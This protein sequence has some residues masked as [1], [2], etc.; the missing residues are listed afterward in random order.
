MYLMAAICFVT[1]ASQLLYA[2]V[3]IGDISL[4]LKVERHKH[5]VVAADM[6]WPSI[7]YRR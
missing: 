3:Y 4:G 2:F 1:N 6:K 5:K 7:M